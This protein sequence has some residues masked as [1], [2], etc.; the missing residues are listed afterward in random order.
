MRSFL[1]RDILSLKDFDR[2]GDGKLSLGEFPGPDDHF[3]CFDSNRDG[4]LEENELPRHPPIQGGPG[5]DG[6]EGPGR[7]GPRA[8]ARPTKRRAGEGWP[9]GRR[10]VRRKTRKHA[11]GPAT[12]PYRYRVKATNAE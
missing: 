10:P 4:F 9:D 8:G 7:G 5:L 11:H 3:V 1:G 2:D 6:R 12:V